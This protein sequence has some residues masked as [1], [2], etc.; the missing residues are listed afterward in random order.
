MKKQLIIGLDLSQNSTGITISYLENFDG[1]KIDFYR[2][3]FDDETNKTGKIYKPKEITNITNIVYHMPNNIEVTDLLLD[4]EDNNNLE[5]CEITLKSMINS[6]NICKILFD[7]IEK[8]LPDNI[9]LSIENYIMPAFS[10]KNQLKTVSGLIQLQGFVRK[11]I[12]KYCLLKKIQLKLLT[13]TPTTVKSFFALDGGADKLKMFE[14]FNKY[15]NGKLLLP[16]VTI[17]DLG[18]INDVIDSFAL[19]M[20]AYSKIIKTKEYEKVH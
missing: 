15:Y 8:H 16:D 12:I 19:M 13:P 9:Y 17:L 10:G 2:I 6:S 7:S 14:S 11:E 20:Y 4:K 5:Q 1:K 3:V 18:K